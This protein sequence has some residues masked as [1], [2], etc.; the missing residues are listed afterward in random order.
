[1]TITDNIT[2]AHFSFGVV[3][4]LL[5]VLILGLIKFLKINPLKSDEEKP[6]EPIIIPLENTVQA[7]N[8]LPL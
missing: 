2:F 7:R 6:P 1:M 5:I 4:L 3:S 8:N